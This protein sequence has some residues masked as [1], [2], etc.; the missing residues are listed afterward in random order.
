MTTEHNNGIENLV[1]PSW[2][3]QW[4]F[5]PKVN[6]YYS[7]V[8]R[9]SKEHIV[10]LP[11]SWEL[12]HKY[13]EVEGM[14]ELTNE[15]RSQQIAYDKVLCV[16]K[17]EGIFEVKIRSFTWLPYKSLGLVMEFV[18]GKNLSDLMWDEFGP[19]DE[20]EKKMETGMGKA[21]NLVFEFGDCDFKNAIW[22]EEKQKTYLIDLRYWRLK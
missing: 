14:K 4:F 12:K 3:D 15:L 9:I 11:R 6:K 18:P 5:T 16:P 8:Q 2:D 17:P 10:K 7:R 21:R 19:F 20:A 22:N 1:F 13:T